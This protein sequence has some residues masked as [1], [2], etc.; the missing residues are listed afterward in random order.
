MMMMMMIIVVDE[1][2][3]IIITGTYDFRDEHNKAQYLTL[4]LFWLLEPII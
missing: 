2:I 1:V 3:I 4:T